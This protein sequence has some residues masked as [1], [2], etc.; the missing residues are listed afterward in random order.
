MS[1]TK[2]RQLRTPRAENIPKT[3]KRIFR[4]LNQYPWQMFLVFFCLIISALANVA[5][6]YFFTPIIDHYVVPYIGQ[7]NPDLTEFIRMLMMMGGIYVTAVIAS[8]IWN[9]MMSHVTT[10]VLNDVRQQLFAKMQDMPVSFY[11]S[12]THG[13][14]MNFYTNDVDTMRPL[15]A[16]TLP[17]AFSTLF[18][19]VGVFIM[20]LRLNVYLTVVAFISIMLMALVTYVLGKSGRKYFIQIQKSVSNINGYV[21]EMFQGQKVV[22]VFNHEEEA[23]RGFKKYNDETFHASVMTN[24]FAGM[25]MPINAN[26]SYVTYAIVAVLGA[27]LCIEGKMSLGILSSFL[28]YTRQIAGPISN[29]SQQFNGMMMAISG[30]ERVFRIIDSKPET[31]EGRIELVNV[32]YEDG[33]MKEVA[34]VTNDYAWK[35]PATGEL[36]ALK[37]DIRLKNVTF[38]YEENKVVLKNIS[39]YAK[40]GQKIAFVGSTGAG[41]TTIT[42]L[43]NRFYDV[44]EGEI[45]YDGINIKKIRKAALRNSLGVVLQDTNLFSGTVM[46][47]IRYGNLQASDE[48]CKEAARLANADG[49][50]QRLPQGYNTMLSAN[51]ANLSQGQRQLLNIARAAVANPPV[52]I[53]DEATSSIDTHTERL[54]E[55]GM[56]K[57]MAGRTVFVIAHRLSTIRNSNAIIVLEH[58][59]IIER[60]DHDELLKQ[61]G[62]YYQLYTGKAE[63]D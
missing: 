7:E 37:G 47:N 36:T 60:G 53:L 62:R 38:G 8:W 42:N 15:L 51:G 56:D 31:D 9:R 43:I 23:V 32:R 44:D 13:E 25:L 61:Q 45:T 10:G 34:E 54:I 19:I 46:E 49:F 6:S 20:M 48:Q 28:L 4:Y 5:S 55:K 50:I 26:L 63:L 11:D 16:E 59:E 22:K 58:G 24:T 41:K 1:E 2:Y 3:V 17:T 39:L 29:L 57:L 12:H 52:L 33:Q 21:E 18:N 14:L 40:P 30:A 27:R 35:D